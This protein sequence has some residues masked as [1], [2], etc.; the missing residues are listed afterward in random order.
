MEWFGSIAHKE[1]SVGGDDQGESLLT[2][3]LKKKKIISL[4]SPPPKC[5]NTQCFAKNNAKMTN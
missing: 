3:Y 1:Q 5:M 2:D 4:I